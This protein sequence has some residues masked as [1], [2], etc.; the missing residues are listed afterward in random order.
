MN[1]VRT[2][3]LLLLGAI[4]VAL[5]ATAVP[6]SAHH[7]PIP[8]GFPDETNTG[9]TDPSAL[10]VHHGTLTVREDNTVVENLE[11]RGKLEINGAKNVTVR[12]VWVYTRSAYQVRVY[13]G[14]SMTIEDS[15]IGNPDVISTYGSR[16]LSGTNITARRLNIHHV[17]DGIKLGDDSTYD[18]I[19]CHDLA[20]DRSSPHMD[21]TQDDGGG[22]NWSITNSTLDANHQN[23]AVII[24]S[25]LHP[26]RNVVVD[27]NYLNGGN[28]T[29]FDRDGGN[30][31]PQGVRITNN[32]FG[33]DFHYGLVSSDGGMDWQGNHWAD[34]GELIDPSGNPIGGTVPIPPPVEKPTPLPPHAHDYELEVSQKPDRSS[35]VPLAG[36]DLAGDVYIHITPSDDIHHVS[37]YLDGA[38]RPFDT[39]YNAPYDVGGTDEDGNALPFHAGSLQGN[40]H[41]ISAEVETSD[42]EHV[43]ID[44]DFTTHPPPPGPEPIHVWVSDSPDRSNPRPLAAENLENDAYIF[45][46]PTDGVHRVLFHLDGSVDPVRHEQNPPFDFVGGDVHTARPLDPDTLA[47]GPHDIKVVVER[48]NGSHSSLDVAFTTGPPPGPAV[49]HVVYSESANRADPKPLHGANVTGDIYVFA[50]PTDGVDR[51]LF[52][53][54]GSTTPDRIENNPPFDLI[55]GNVAAAR[56]WDTDA[57]DPGPHS[58]RVVYE[59]TSGDTTESTANFTTGGP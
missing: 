43:R 14:G 4:V 52:Y 13:N 34:T 16:G 55:G 46:T 58:V 10:E 32:L 23:S 51:A 21:C 33:R 35:S 12:N 30:G 24:K 38:D 48:T 50:E 29:I 8:Q 6:A 40:H 17:E 44:A 36:S 53:I 47:D 39:E 42:G 18:R 9:L 56:P 37:Y 41:R 26:I 19:Y 7:E 5:V 31:V 3:V 2:F 15:E 45:V 11:I 49:P 54:D 57:L 20:S 22:E 1:S 25:D 59:W 28:Y 27:G